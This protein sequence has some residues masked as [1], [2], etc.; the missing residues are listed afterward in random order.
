MPRSCTRKRPTTTQR[1]HT[2]SEPNA[3]RDVIC[4]R[5][6]HQAA[7]GDVFGLAHCLN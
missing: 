1:V 4:I 6:N 7:V 5:Y 2:L 3:F